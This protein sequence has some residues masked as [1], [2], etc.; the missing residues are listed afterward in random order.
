[1][2]TENE[3]IIDYQLKLLSIIANF[4]PFLSTT[5]ILEIVELK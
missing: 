3:D 2:M 5:F 1:M 4:H